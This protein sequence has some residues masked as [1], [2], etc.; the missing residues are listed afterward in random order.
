MP[1]RKTM[2]RC[3]PRMPKMKEAEVGEGSTPGAGRNLD[4]VSKI[5]LV[6]HTSTKNHFTQ[7]LAFDDT[8]VSTR[9]KLMLPHW[10]DIFRKIIQE[11]YLELTPHIDPDVRI[12]YD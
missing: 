12:L 4:F 9:Y 11:Y 10:G 1:P 6:I 7:P 3:S 2:T 8:E 5:E